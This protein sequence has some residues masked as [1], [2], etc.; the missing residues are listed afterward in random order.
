M[1][2]LA[3]KATPP[4]DL[5]YDHQRQII[6]ASPTCLT[7]VTPRV[8]VVPEA[9]PLFVAI[10]TVDLES[11]WESNMQMQYQSHPFRNE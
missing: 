5:V 2:G 10:S 1:K 6:T 3:G 8:L 9:A 7:L 4:C 11:N